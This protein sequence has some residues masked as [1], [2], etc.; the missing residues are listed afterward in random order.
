MAE[1]ILITHRGG[2]RLSQITVILSTRKQELI[3]G[4][5]WMVDDLYRD[6]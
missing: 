4:Q 2:P 1:F 3:R 6:Q 5:E